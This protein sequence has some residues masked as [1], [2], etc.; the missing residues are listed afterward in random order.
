MALLRD[1]ERF[2]AAQIAG[3]R[4]V[5]TRYTADLMLERYRRIY[6]TAIGRA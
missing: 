2:R 4:R 3:I 1:P 5:E 6:G